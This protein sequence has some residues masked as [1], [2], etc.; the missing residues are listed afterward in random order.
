VVD[1]IVYTGS[2]ADP[3]WFLDAIGHPETGR[4]AI[5]D[6]DKVNTFVGIKISQDKEKGVMTLS[7]EKYINSMVGEIHQQHGQEV[8]GG[9]CCACYVTP[10]SW[11][12][13]YQRH[14][15]ED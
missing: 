15:T 12:A 6:L 14:G 1:D 5:K 7:Q 3:R 8:P 2:D 9:T 13:P 11:S 10:A 4:F